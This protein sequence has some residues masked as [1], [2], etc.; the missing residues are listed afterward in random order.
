VSFELVGLADAETEDRLNSVFSP[1]N[2]AAG[3]LWTE[4]DPDAEDDDRCGRRGE[5]C[6]PTARGYR[7]LCRDSDGNPRRFF[8]AHLQPT[9]LDSTVLSVR[10]EYRFDGGGVLTHGISGM[11]VDLGSGRPTLAND[12][13]KDWLHP[14]NWRQLVSKSSTRIP[15]EVGDGVALGLFEEDENESEVVRPVWQET[16]WSTFYVTPTGFALVP[17]AGDVQQ[18]V[19]YGVQE[20]PFAKVRSA[21]R[22]DGPIA[23]LWSQ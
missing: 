4:A 1:T 16:I 8:S 22:T 12:I 9:L 6:D 11:T 13:L 10:D 21:L 20:V 2:V 23:H 14:P 7:I 17:Q 5:Y 15:D 18:D 19:P 3:Y